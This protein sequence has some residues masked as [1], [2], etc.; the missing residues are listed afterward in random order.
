M[1]LPSP[2]RHIAL[3]CI[4]LAQLAPTGA[5]AQSVNESEFS[6]SGSL[7]HFDYREFNDNGRLLDHE[8]GY[9][10]GLLLGISQSYEQWAFAGNL[11][12]HRGDTAYIGYTNTGIPIT[13]TTQQNLAGL[14]LQAE[15]WL[16]RTQ[17]GDLAVYFGT[18]YRQWERDILSTTTAGGSPV[19]GLFETYTWWSGFAGIKAALFD[20]GYGRCLLDM[21][22]AQTIAP[23]I[24]VNFH[25]NYDNAQL[26]LAERWGARLA[27]PW[28][29]AL[30]QDSSLLVEPYAEYHEF[31]RS[32]AAPLTSNGAVV[33][34]LFEP[35]SQTMVFGV[36][37]GIS[38]RF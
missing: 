1:Y 37:V 19:G 36:L 22:I 28:R 27:L 13:T 18:G 3:Q 14:S 38:Q 32:S 12:L 30:E 2:L 6:I 9:L 26:A 5:S 15:Y 17:G 25:G 33:G 34:S 7:M 4:L 29:Y 20:A 21:R 31:G 10:P 23:A 24:Q 8:E 35:A 16:S 11:S